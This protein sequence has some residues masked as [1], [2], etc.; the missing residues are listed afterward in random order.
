MAAGPVLAG[1]GFPTMFGEIRDQNVTFCVDTSGSMYNHLSVV[2]DHLTEALLKIA[3]TAPDKTFNIVEFSTEVDQWADRMVK[4]TPHTVTRA[5]GWIRALTPKTGTN[6][7][8]ALLTALGDPGCTAVYLVTDGL[9]DQA[10][11]DIL[12][13]VAYSSRGRPIH[14]IFLTHTFAD[15]AAHDFLQ[16]LAVQTRG[17][18]HIITL[19]VEGNVHRVTPVYRADHSGKR[20]LGGPLYPPLKSSSVMTRLDHNPFLEGTDPTPIVTYTPWEPTVS[21]TPLDRVVTVP[22]VATGTYTRPL[23]LRNTITGKIVDTTSL[24]F[25]PSASLIMRG[26]RVLARRDE[27]GYYYMGT[28]ANQLPDAK[29]RFMIEFD[30]VP[31]LKSRMQET[32]I[33][34]MI[35]HVDAFRH[36]IV[37]GDKVLAPWEVTGQRF[38]P[39]TVLE[40]V[41][42]RFEDSIDD[43]EDL[44]V[45][46]WNGKTESVPRHKA[47]WIPL[48]L[49]ERVIFELQMPVAAREKFLEANP[50]WPYESPP[51]YPSTYIVG[52]PAEFTPPKPARIRSPHLVS[53]TRHVYVPTHYPTYP[54]PW[55]WYPAV[56]STLETEDDGKIPGADVTKD[57]LNRKVLQQ[58]RENKLLLDDTREEMKDLRRSLK[59]SKSID[60]GLSSLSD[61]EDWYDYEDYTPRDKST[62]TDWS[63]YKDTKGT[64]KDERPPWRYWSRTPRSPVSKAPHPPTSKPMKRYPAFRDTTVNT[65][66]ELLRGPND[67]QVVE[68]DVVPRGSYGQTNS[69]KLTPARP[70][71]APGNGRKATIVTGPNDYD[72]SVFNT[73]NHSQPPAQ[74]PQGPPNK[75]SAFQNVDH[76]FRRSI[77]MREAMMHPQPPPASPY[78]AQRQ[79]E[80]SALSRDVEP[81]SLDM[82]LVPIE[83]FKDTEQNNMQIVP[84]VDS[85]QDKR[86]RFTTIKGSPEHERQLL[87]TTSE[88]S[89]KCRA[90]SKSKA[91]RVL[92]AFENS[93]GTNIRLL[94]ERE[95]SSVNSIELLHVSGNSF[96]NEVKSVIAGKNESKSKD[97]SVSDVLETDYGRM[98]CDVHVKEMLRRKDIEFLSESQDLGNHSM[99]G[100][101]VASQSNSIDAVA[102]VVSE[103]DFG[104]TTRNCKISEKSNKQR[105]DRRHVSECAQMAKAHEVQQT[106]TSKAKTVNFSETTETEHGTCLQELHMSEKSSK[107]QSEESILVRDDSGLQAKI[108]SGPSHNTPPSSWDKEELSLTQSWLLAGW[109]PNYN[110]Y[111]VVTHKCTKLTPSSTGTSDLTMV[112]A[113]TAVQDSVPSSEVVPLHI[114]KPPPPKQRAGPPND[115]KGYPLNET[116]GRNQNILSQEEAE[117]TLSDF[118][119]RREMLRRQSEHRQKSEAEEKAAA[120]QAAKRQQALQFI[121]Q[122]IDR[123]E[124]NE[125]KVQDTI[126]AK[127]SI[128]N[129]IQQHE[130]NREDGHFQ[131]DQGRV[132]ALR[133]RQVQ[134]EVLQQQR[135]QEKED[136]I[137]RRREGH[138]AR[139]A[140]HNLQSEIKYDV[141]QGKL[142]TRD[143]RRKIAESQRR[144]FFHKKEMAAQDK[145]NLKATVDEQKLQMYRSHV[146]P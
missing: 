31:T 25:S 132:S 90:G 78:L 30:K 133:Q 127:R 128:T 81:D 110:S 111:G 121:K 70:Y 72:Y 99:Q 97:M 83:T 46:F 93:N 47:I 58:L 79:D 138:E 100:L 122:D 26:T 85:S 16:D 123:H 59:K 134:H 77:D 63:L 68:H 130:R 12:Q 64:Q 40:G 113:Q 60:S 27:D 139:V 10:P 5:A 109:K 116:V 145:K 95:N 53:S 104:K 92:E 18:F 32:G 119:R 34:D 19:T 73:V 76:T 114:P 21:Y 142:Q 35:A 115:S 141:E 38:G 51:G 20:P 136:T 36:K 135:M 124:S 8:D 17:S 117:N 125:K 2:K 62:N 98:A 3:Y 91:R 94:K 118:R 42:R 82:Q 120:I 146:L 131:R 140:M 28:V 87:R 11:H 96:G 55:Y 84:V 54:Y 9:P 6:T 44:V 106:T 13:H 24:E 56:P 69:R 45:T 144:E 89:V 71:T 4:C 143:A 105:I 80:S 126:E 74:P 49:Y 75:S 1:R 108:T 103:N 50:G 33:Y 129:S 107:L 67:E 37:P 41:E 112:P 7:L 137:R 29:G 101:H 14:C 61:Y 15:A 102:H 88:Q 52:D 86:V 57:Q 39:G 22:S 48:M 65:P 23:K 66:M 43:D